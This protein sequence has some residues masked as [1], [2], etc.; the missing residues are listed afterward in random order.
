M[1]KEVRMDLFQHVLAHRLIFYTGFHRH[2][3]F[4]LYLNYE[5]IACAVEIFLYLQWCLH[6][7]GLVLHLL[8]A[9]FAKL[10]TGSVILSSFKAGLNLVKLHWP[11]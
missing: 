1:H 8:Y 4:P 10:G 9:V 7:F 6:E 5:I 11:C 3:V 2:N